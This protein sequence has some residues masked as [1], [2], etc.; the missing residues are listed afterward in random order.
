MLQS[1][2]PL[3]DTFI[4]AFSHAKAEIILPSHE[5]EEFSSLYR[6]TCGFVAGILLLVLYGCCYRLLMCSC[7]LKHVS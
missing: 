5:C 1:S 7:G 2:A 6:F 3:K 4:R